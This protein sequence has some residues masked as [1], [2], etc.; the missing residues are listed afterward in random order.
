MSTNFS[1]FT[2]NT[3]PATVD[4]VVGYNNTSTGGEKRWAWS[5]VRTLFY[6]GVASFTDATDA[7]S[8][9]TASVK[10]A[11]GLAV[12]KA[13][14]S[15][16]AIT[17]LANATNPTVTAGTLLHLVSADAAVGT[18]LIEG[19]GAGASYNGRA[20]GGT[21]ASPSATTAGST[22]VQISG[23]GWANGAYTGTKGYFAFKT[24]NLWSASDNST[25]FVIGLTPTGS[26][27]RADA[28]VITNA[29][30]GI[31]GTTSGTFLV[32][33]AAALAQTLTLAPAAQTVGAATVTIPDMAG[34]SDTFAFLGKTQTFTGVITAP[35]FVS[36]AGGGTA[37]YLELTQGTAPSAGTTSIKFYAPTSV[38]SYIRTF[39]GAAGTGFYLGTN[40][41]G[42]VTDTQVASIGSGSVVLSAG[43][44]A[45][46]TAKTLT[47]TQSLTL[48][49]TDSTTMTFPTTSATLARTDAG[50][51]FTGV[52][53]AT[54]WT[55]VTP[56]LGTPTSGTLTNCTIPIGGVTG[57]TNHN[58]ATYGASGLGTGI[59]PGSSGNVLTS[60][61]TDWTSAAAKVVKIAVFSLD[62]GG[63]AAIVTGTVS[64]T[65]RIPNACTL[66]GWSITATAAS[67]TNTVKFWNTATGTAIPTIANVINTSG[68][69]LTTGTAVASA[70]L[71][72]FT[73]TSYAAGDMIRCAITAVDGTATD[74]TVTLYGT[75]N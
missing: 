8:L 27:T 63:G 30:Y 42:V 18:I 24:V 23:Q 6:A 48:S 45:V 34:V 58:V 25:S 3:A 21:M 44:L 41:A 26:T 37:G 32:A 70:T 29:Y 59:A 52:S 47:V 43:A 51:T 46:T 22:L 19:A 69:S 67:G 53:T 9:T 33:P 61:G 60:N 35:G 12:T 28:F 55:L 4:Y 10:M 54:S 57:G 56:V 39:P 1:Q 38:T 65:A 16:T 20:A 71:S 40:A 2:A 17:V 64:G 14:F 15:G 49:G 72:D 31:N 66:T 68:V 73:D 50:Q 7:S 11:G 74:L 75:L 5:D 13:I 62:G 36:S